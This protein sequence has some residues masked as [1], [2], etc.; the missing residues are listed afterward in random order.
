[1]FPCGRKRIFPGL[2]AEEVTVIKIV[3]TSIEPSLEKIFKLKPDLILS[4]DVQKKQTYKQLS[5]IALIAPR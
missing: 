2:S 4:L 3:G 5:G 1:M